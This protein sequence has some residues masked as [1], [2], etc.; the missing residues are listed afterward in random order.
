MNDIIAFLFIAAGVFFSAI[1]PI[2]I[3]WVNE[4]FRPQPTG[5]ADDIKQ[6]AMTYFVLAISSLIIAFVT[7]AVVKKLVGGHFTN[8]YEPFIVGYLYDS[9]LQKTKSGI[10]G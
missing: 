7:L 4:K 8:W 3:K 10:V 9:T 6:F 2:A 5:L 1:V